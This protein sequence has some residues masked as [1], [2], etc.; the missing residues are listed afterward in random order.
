MIKLA[1]DDSWLV[2]KGP[3]HSCKILELFTAVEATAPPA[4][5][6]TRDRIS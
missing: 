6:H 2:P 3:G 4:Q 1:P 5:V